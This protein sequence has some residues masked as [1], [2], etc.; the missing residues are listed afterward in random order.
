MEVWIEMVV[1]VLFRFKQCQGLRMGL[2]K[3]EG[4]FRSEKEQE[5]SVDITADTYIL[6][7]S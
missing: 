6:L 1:R 5:G 2:K 7:L 3:A 4:F